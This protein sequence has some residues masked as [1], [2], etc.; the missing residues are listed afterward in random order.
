MIEEKDIEVIETMAKK[1][2]LNIISFCK[3]IIKSKKKSNQIQIKL[4]KE[5]YDHIMQ[6]KGNLDNSQYCYLACEYHLKKGF[7]LEDFRIKKDKRTYRIAVVL[8][9]EKELFKVL[10]PY[11]IKI[12]TLVRFCALNFK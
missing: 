1:Y 9:N 5:E 10:E 6:K 12:S 8:K 3:E 4:S 7:N 2:N 11:S